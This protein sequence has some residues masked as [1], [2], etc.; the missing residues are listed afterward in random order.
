MMPLT[1]IQPQRPDWS[2]CSMRVQDRGDAFDHEERDQHSVS[3]TDPLIGQSSSTTP[4]AMAISAEIS[5]H[6]KPGP[7]RP[8]GRDQADDA[9]DQKDPADDDGQG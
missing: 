9:A 4:A 5:A 3:E 6:Q 7:G 2:R 8:E 1:S